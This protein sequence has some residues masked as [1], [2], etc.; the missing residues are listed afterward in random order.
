[1]IAFARVNSIELRKSMNIKGLRIERNSLEFKGLF[2][3]AYS[4]LVIENSIFRDFD[5]PEKHILITV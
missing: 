4:S 2:Y 3:V 1:L 5:F